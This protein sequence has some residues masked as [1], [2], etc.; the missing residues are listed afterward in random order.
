VAVWL[1]NRKGEMWISTKLTPP[2]NSMLTHVVTVYC[3]SDDTAVLNTARRCE[4]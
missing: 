3:V 2:P 4:F 1:L